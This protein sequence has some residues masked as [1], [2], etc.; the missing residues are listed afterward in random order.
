MRRYQQHFKALGSSVNLTLIAENETSVNPVFELLFNSINTFE[1]CFSRF[2]P[3]SELTYVNRQAGQRT[4]VSPAMMKILKASIDL[5]KM[6]NGL[7]S[8]FILPPLQRAGYV[9]SIEHGFKTDNAL[10]DYSRRSFSDS[11]AIRF[12]VNWVELPSDSAIDL[13]GIGKGYLL[14][15]LAV[16][17]R[18]HKTVN[19]CLSLGGDIICHG[20]DIDAS[21]WQVQIAP[22]IT[23]HE[24]HKRIIGKGNKLAIATSGTIK[25]R[26]SNWHHLIDPRSGLPAETDI[27]SATVVAGRAATA[28]VIAKAI[29]IGGQSVADNFLSQGHL[30]A[31]LLQY[32]NKDV[33]IRGEYIQ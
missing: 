14:D 29:V 19:Y 16:Y 21:G 28:D 32:K 4:L 18:A 24:I 9:G 2:L 31:Y 33:I 3:T 15:E 10:L 6:S 7:F 8:P 5:S 1:Q 17:L 23:D 20:R 11:Q 27:L 30:K 12:G 22:A 25:R 13:G 26:G